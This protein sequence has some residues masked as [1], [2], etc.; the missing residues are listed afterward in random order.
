[1]V[2]HTHTMCQNDESGSVPPS[3]PNHYRAYCGL[4]S[5]AA[6]LGYH[7]V[8]QPGGPLSVAPNGQVLWA[9]ARARDVTA[10]TICWGGGVG[11][12]ARQPQP[13]LCFPSGLR[14]FSVVGEEILINSVRPRGESGH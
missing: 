7:P 1:M 8:R 6:A 12:Q 10:V 9:R 2:A 13:P 14:I 3:P 4:L 11:E 5:P